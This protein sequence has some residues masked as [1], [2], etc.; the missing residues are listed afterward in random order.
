LL[1]KGSLRAEAIV[2]GS[3]GADQVSLNKVDGIFANFGTVQGGLIRTAEPNAF[4]VEIENQAATNYPLWYGSRTKGDQY[5]L[6]YVT[7]DGNVVIKG[8]LDASIIKGT[9]FTPAN[10]SLD[11]DPF[12]IATQYN[13]TDYRGETYEAR[14]GKIAHLLPMQ[15][16]NE[17]PD[18]DIDVAGQGTA[19]DYFSPS[20]RFFGPNYSGSQSYNRFGTYTEMFM[21]MF[22]AAVEG[23][24]NGSPGAEDSSF[25][26]PNGNQA[27]ITLQ[28][29]YDN[30]SYKD[31]ANIDIA[32]VTPGQTSGAWTQVF[33]SRSTPWSTLD[34]RLKVESLFYSSPYDSGIFGTQQV[35]SVSLTVFSPNFGVADTSR[36]NVTVNTKLGSLPDYPVM[37]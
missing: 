32:G 6:F 26:K 9:L 12:R 30:N 27:R 15:S 13:E 17:A 20:L 33:A 22:S 34:L 18:W 1:I 25:I 14:G 23:A 5:G 16:M 37:A 11:Y 24:A 19:P 35:K 36:Q 2:A 3:I 21:V 7:Q 4:R 29:R 10:T 28:Y 8:N 31:L